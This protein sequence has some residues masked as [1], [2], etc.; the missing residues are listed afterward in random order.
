VIVAA[1]V[2]QETVD[3]HQLLPMLAQIEKNLERNP[4]KA[5]A[6]A[7]YSLFNHDQGRSDTAFCTGEGGF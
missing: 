6:D 2:T 7:G 3:T 1:E 5:S 4:E